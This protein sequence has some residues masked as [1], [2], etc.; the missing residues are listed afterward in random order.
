MQEIQGF[1]SDHLSLAVEVCR[2]LALCS[3]TLSIAETRLGIRSHREES[4]FLM[5]AAAMPPLLTPLL[6]EISPHDLEMA[7]TLIGVARFVLIFVAA[8][9]LAEVLVRCLLYTSPSPRD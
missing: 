5:L 4:T 9:V 7:E 8:R 6:A 3:C 1:Q 2:P